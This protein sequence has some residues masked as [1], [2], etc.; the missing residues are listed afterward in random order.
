MQIAHWA[1]DSAREECV[2]CLVG[3]SGRPL[4]G[5]VFLRRLARLDRLSP[6]PQTSPHTR[7]TP[8]ILHLHRATRREHVLVVLRPN[9]AQL[10]APCLPGPDAA[11]RYPLGKHWTQLELPRPG[12]LRSVPL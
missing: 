2:Y 7:R 11:L 5:L 12:Q 3:T 1:C 10:S 6:R 8:T 4:Q 9:S